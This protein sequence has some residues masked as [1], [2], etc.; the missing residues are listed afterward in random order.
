MIAIIC[1]AFPPTRFVAVLLANGA[2]PDGKDQT[3]DPAPP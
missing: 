3:P 2:D 1:G